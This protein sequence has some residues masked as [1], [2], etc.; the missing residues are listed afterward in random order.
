MDRSLGGFFRLI[1]RPSFSA[2]IFVIRFVAA[3][4]S[5]TVLMVVPPIFTFGIFTQWSFNTLT[6]WRNLLSIEI[7]LS[8]FVDIVPMTKEDEGA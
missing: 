2:V 6:F 3:P 1:L 7:V 8:L 4:W 5:A